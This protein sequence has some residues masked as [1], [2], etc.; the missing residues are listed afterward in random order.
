MFS[1][2]NAIILG[3]AMRAG[4]A[5]LGWSQ[6]QLAENSLVSLPTIARIEAGLISPRLQTISRLITSM[7]EAGVV[8]AW[9]DPT[10]DFSMTVSFSKKR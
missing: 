4:R 7:E 3:S 2:T 6:Q 8:F 5:A 9:T 1:S 10:N